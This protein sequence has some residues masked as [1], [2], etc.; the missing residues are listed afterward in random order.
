MF[1]YLG[2]IFFT[3]KLESDVGITES[4]IV[5]R[6]Q[7]VPFDQYDTDCVVPITD[8]TRLTVRFDQIYQ[9]LQT[10]QRRSV[11]AMTLLHHFYSI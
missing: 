11:T 9:I 7:I 3:L 5:H 1:R 4:V 10:C 6:Q 2:F 8:Y